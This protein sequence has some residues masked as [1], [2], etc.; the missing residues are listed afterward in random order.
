MAVGLEDGGE[1]VGRGALAVGARHVDGLVARVWMAE[2][3]VEGVGVVQAVLVGRGAHVLEDGGAVEKIFYCLLV[4]HCCVLMRRTLLVDV[5]L[6]EAILVKTC[7]TVRLK[8]A[9]SPT[10]LSPGHRPGYN[11]NQ[12]D[13]L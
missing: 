6:I 8:R 1:G 9:E 7:R 2:M 11:G 13:A 10:V 5:R 12:Q 4:V 3:V